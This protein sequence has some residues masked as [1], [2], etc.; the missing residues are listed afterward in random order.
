MK[1]IL[2]QQLKEHNRRNLREKVCLG[3]SRS[4]GSGSFSWGASDRDND[5]VWRVG[6]KVHQ[7][8]GLTRP[9]FWLRCGPFVF[10]AP[11]SQLFLALASFT[12]SAEF[13]LQSETVIHPEMK[14]VSIGG[15]L[16]GDD[17]LRLRC[18]SN[19]GLRELAEGVAIATI[20][21]FGNDGLVAQS[22]RKLRGN[23]ECLIRVVFKEDVVYGG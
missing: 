9:R 10:P 3:R 4:V 23:P 22:A 5:R 11:G 21:L 12:A 14:P 18:E 13:R 17:S 1:N 8:A 2:L 6:K 15:E 16:I 7:T 19:R 20:S